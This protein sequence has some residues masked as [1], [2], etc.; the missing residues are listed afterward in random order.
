MFCQHV[1]SALTWWWWWL[2]LSQ[3]FHQTS[4]VLQIY[5]KCEFIQSS[6]TYTDQDKTSVSGEYFRTASMPMNIHYQNA[7][8]P[9][10]PNWLYGLYIS[11]VHQTLTVH[12]YST[13][14]TDCTSVPDTDKT[15]I[16]S[17]RQELYALLL[18]YISVCTE[19]TERSPMDSGGGDGTWCTCLH[20]PCWPM[21]TSPMGLSLIMVIA[22]SIVNTMGTQQSGIY[23]SEHEGWVDSVDHWNSVFLQ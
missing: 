10:L 14:D 22:T 9:V 18:K 4:C 5:N 11:T 20:Q 16:N 13:P 6:E 17:I 15:S 8:W 3:R 21:S 2:S 7:E 12:Q 19:A 23:R 1:H